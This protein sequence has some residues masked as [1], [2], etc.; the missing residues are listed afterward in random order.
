VTINKVVVTQLDWLF[1]INYNWRDKIYGRIMKKYVSFFNQLLNYFK[2][3]KNNIIVIYTFRTTLIGIVP[4][5]LKINA[6][7]ITYLRL[8]GSYFVYFLFFIMQSVF[9]YNINL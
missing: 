2:G 7:R 5:I 3:I 1:M 9:I 8:S 6:I 4:L